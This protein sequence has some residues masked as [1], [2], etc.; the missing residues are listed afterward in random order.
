MRRRPPARFGSERALAWPG[1]GMFVLGFISVGWVGCS[2]RGDPGQALSAPTVTVSLTERGPV[3]DL[4]LVSGT[5]Q[6][7][8]G[9]SA[10][11][12]VLVPGRLAEL[13]VAEGDSVRRGQ[14]LARLEPM[15]FRDSRAQAAA[16]LQQAE[17]QAMNSHQHLAR[18]ADLWDA[19][20][21][22]L[23]DV[24]DAQ[25]QLAAAEAAVK[26]NAAALS[27][28]LNQATRGEVIAPMDSVVSHVYAA[29]GEPMDGSGKP[30]LEVAQVDILELQGG[31]PPGRAGRLAPGQPADVAVSGD[32]RMEPGIVRAVSPA[33]DAAS[34]LV[35]VR[36]QVAN[37]DGHLKVGVTAEARVVLLL[38]P[39][40][41]RIPLAA[42]IPSG[43]GSVGISVNV[44]TADG[45]A[46]RQ[47]VEVGVKDA[48]Y[49]EIIS[50]LTVGDRVI[51]G[52][53]YA[54]PDGTAVEV[55]DGGI[56]SEKL[57]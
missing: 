28:T 16:A 38:I 56:R 29:V 21:G 7:S 17:A 48:V 55:A 45:R 11:L 2:R 12:G 20:A 35:R 13:S 10:R 39:D 23:K 49:A 22:P 46:R 24:E 25:A 31:A 43:P 30:I 27:L 40:A 4:L 19:G 50:G 5:L 54:L 53:S 3:A 26:T 6:P 33:V 52:G 15:P 47:A 1:L 37:P 32:A 51:L 9:K 14:I 34:G 41:I 44:V 42:L 8:P 36:V 57:Q 18:A